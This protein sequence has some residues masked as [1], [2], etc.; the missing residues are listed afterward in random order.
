MFELEFAQTFTLS[1]RFWFS[2]PNLPKKGISDWKQK[3]WTSHWILLIWIS[4]GTKFQLKLAILIFWIKFT[5]KGYFW[6]KI[7]KV[8]TITEFCIFE[9]ILCT[10]F[11]LELTILIIWTKF[12][13]RGYF[14]Y[15]TEKSHFCVQ[16]WSLLHLTFPD[17]GRQTKR[18]FNI[19]SLVAETLSYLTKSDKPVL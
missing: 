8:K 10:K 14:Q 19:S 18:H 1:W 9:L 13:Q 15:K 6:S 5:Q 2:G 12:A 3:K 16:P 17:R 11:Q 7:E 4:L